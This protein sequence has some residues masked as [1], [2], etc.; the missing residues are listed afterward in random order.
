MPTIRELATLI[1]ADYYP[2]INPVVFPNT[3]AFLYWSSTF[4]DTHYTEAWLINFS[5]GLV[6]C[7]YC[8]CSHH[9][10]L[11]RSD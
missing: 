11:V 4:D 6:N 2:A 8:V 1:D 10:R 9:V 7:G 5:D 3:P